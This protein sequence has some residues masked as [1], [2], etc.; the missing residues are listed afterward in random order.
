M[1]AFNFKIQFT[2]SQMIREIKLFG[3]G[4]KALDW[5]IASLELGGHIRVLEHRLLA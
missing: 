3:E 2:D 1:Q 5:L 4:E